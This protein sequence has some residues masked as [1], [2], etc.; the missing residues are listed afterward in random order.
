ARILLDRHRRGGPLPLGHHGVTV[1]LGNHPLHVSH[2]VVASDREL[3]RVGPYRLVLCDRDGEH[4]I[5]LQASA[6]TH[7][8]DMIWG[9]GGLMGLLD[10]LVDLPG[11]R[12]VAGNPLV[13]AAHLSITAGT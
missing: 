12:L 6:L 7:D 5:T 3:A 10:A 1:G 13:S 8:P 2:H 11:R 9:G 4:A